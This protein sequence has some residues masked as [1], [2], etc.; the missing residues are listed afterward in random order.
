MSPILL[1]VF[2]ASS[3]FIPAQT[4][5]SQPSNNEEAFISIRFSQSGMDCLKSMLTSKVLQSITPLIFNKIERTINVPLLGD[6]DLLLSRTRIT[7]VQVYSCCCNKCA[8]GSGVQ[9]IAWGEVC[10]LTIN[11]H[12]PFYHWLA[13]NGCAGIKVTG[14]QLGK[15]LD[16]AN[17]NGI[18]KLSLVD[19]DYKDNNISVEVN[20]GSWLF[21]IMIHTFQRDI[22]VSVQNAISKKFREQILEL[23]SFLRDVPKEIPID[24][25]SSLDVTLLKSN[26]S[27]IFDMKGLFIS[28][29][30]IPVPSRSFKNTQPSVLCIKEPKVIGISIHEDVLNSASALYYDAKY[31][32][33]IV[34][35]LPNNIVLNTDIVPQLQKLYPNRDM[36]LNISLTSPPIMRISEKKIDAKINAKLIINILEVDAFVPIACFSLKFDGSSSVKIMAGEEGRVRKGG[37]GTT[38]LND[39]LVSL[40]WSKIGNLPAYLFQ[41]AVETLVETVVLPY[42]NAQLRQGFS[43]LNVH[44][45]VFW[46]PEIILSNSWITF[47][48]G[49]AYTEP[50]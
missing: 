10:N 26:S 11:F 50:Q 45:F 22:G 7:Q 25:I 8:D 16:L 47:C 42:A 9:L 28:R 1:F 32:R 48:G 13:D 36:K 43:I 17:D 4:Q 6:V 15:R 39:L 23:D 46:R 19:L 49:L 18:L 35:K 14:M 37:S 5:H 41:P 12:L 24:E 38:K 34:D 30:K 29:N 20:E 27:S 33:W 2:L 21:R 3:L 31:M 40:E 44:G